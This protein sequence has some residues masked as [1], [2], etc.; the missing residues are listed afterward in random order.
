MRLFDFSL[1]LNVNVVLND[2]IFDLMLQETTSNVYLV[3]EVRFILNKP[4]VKKIKPLQVYRSLCEKRIKSEINPFLALVVSFYTAWTSQN[5]LVFDVFRGCRKRAV[6]WN[7]V[8][9][10][11][12]WATQE[13][14]P[15]NTINIYRMS[16]KIYNFVVYSGYCIKDGLQISL[17]LLLSELINI[18]TAWNDQ[19]TIDFLMIS[20]WIEVS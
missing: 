14:D 2:S 17:L 18:Y 19:K 13:I 6:V 8:R 4:Q 15:L 3:M 11:T 16:W 12:D 9:L 1:C 7:G 20:E 10:Y 5:L